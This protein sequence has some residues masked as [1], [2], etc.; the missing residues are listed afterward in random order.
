MRAH[1][2]RM[3]AALGLFA[4]AGAAPAQAQKVSLLLDWAWIPYH[5][6]FLI[7][8][9]RG[10]YKDAG[11][12]VTIEQG[13]G[14]ATTT[15]V[16]GQGTFD[17]GH[18]NITNAAQAI[19]KGVPLKSV[20]VYQQRTAASFIGIKGKVNL[21][22]AASLKTLKIGSTPGGSDALSLALFSKLNNMPQSQLNVVGLDGAAKRA[23]LLNGNVD[24]VSGDSHAYSAIVRGA[25]HQPEML[26]LADL[27]VPLLGFGFVTN[28]TYARSNGPT[29]KK[30]LAASKK[31]FQAGAEDPKK[32]CEFMKTKVLLTGSIEQCVDY[33][34]G[35]LELSQKP[36][37][38]NWGRQSLE[39]WQKLVATLESVNEI[40]PGKAPEAFFTNDFVP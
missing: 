11:L 14:S 39:Q 6:V 26:L 20:A 7:A 25:G 37:D 19:A 12:D 34:T 3:T 4:A 13:R 36:S 18:V 9:E 33:F 31:G 16:V 28:E 17:L 23:A 30:F 29:I 35:L 32:A 2:I 27:G 10:F 1:I 38:P 22:D 8:Q 40:Q 21:K 15:V 5:T 24:V